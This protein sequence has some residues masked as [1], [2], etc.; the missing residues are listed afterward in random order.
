MRPSRMTIV[1]LSIGAPPR[2]SITRAPRRAVVWAS[3]AVDVPMTSAKDTPISEQSRL[4]PPITKSSHLMS[5]ASLLDHLVGGSEQL[6]WHSEAER[7]RSHDTDDQFI[8]GRH[9]DRQIAWLCAPENGRHVM[10]IG[11]A[12]GIGVACAVAHQ[13]AGHDKLASDPDRRHAMTRGE[14]R[15][16]PAP[17]VEQQA[18]TDKQCAGARLNDSRKGSID[19]AYG[20]RSQGQELTSEFACSGR[21]LFFSPFET[22]ISGIAQP[23]NGGWR[24]HQ[25]MQQP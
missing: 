6:V 12:I 3:A 16:L 5:T 1:A 20:L 25:L 23:S 9:L 4:I 21:H 18:A 7:L 14:R 19:F 2:P 24:R 17:G 15:Q 11:A 8:L 10:R 22:R 13:T